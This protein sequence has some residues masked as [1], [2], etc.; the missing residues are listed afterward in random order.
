MKKKLLFAALIVVASTCSAYSQ[1]GGSAAPAAADANT[2]SIITAVLKDAY[3]ANFDTK[4]SC[5]AYTEKDDSGDVGYCMQPGTSEV[6][7]TQGGKQLYLTANSFV[8]PS[9]DGKYIYDHTQPGLMGVFQ[10]KLDGKGGW[11]YVVAKKDLEYGTAG[12]CGCDK[13]KLIKL[14]AKGDYGWLFSNGGMWQGTIV[15]TYSIVV[16]INGA[17]QDISSLPEITEKD[18]NTEYDLKFI[19]LPTRDKFYPIKVTAKNR[20]SGAVVR[21]YLVHYDAKTQ[22]YALPGK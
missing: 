8:G 15:S 4:R 5:W 2:S 3:G 21:D 18:Q 19:D 10:V 22:M 11:S 20:K 1:A 14:N 7:N 6:I 17:Y 16:A 12:V 9:D 13:A